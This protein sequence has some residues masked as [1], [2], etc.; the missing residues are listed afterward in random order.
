M[1]AKRYIINHIS[2]KIY[3]E[4][5]AS[6]VGLSV[7]YLSNIFKKTTGQTLVE[8][9]NTVKLQRVRE[10]RLT[11]GVT[12]KE[13]GK[14]VGFYD[15]TYLSR[16]YKKYFGNNLSEIPKHNIRDKTE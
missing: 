1:K 4:D 16:L 14:T 10:L 6:A 2:E 3:V 8:Y 12:L 13:A 15:E 7:G 11:L 5:I 9:I